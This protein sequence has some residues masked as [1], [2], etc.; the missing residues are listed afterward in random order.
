[1]KPQEGLPMEPILIPVSYG[2]LLDKV[3][4]LR[5]KLNRIKDQDKLANVSKE[6]RLLEEV[7]TKSGI[8]LSDLPIQELE[9]INTALWD[10]EDAIRDKERKREF[11]EEF[12]QLA[13]SVYKINDRR[14]EVKLKINK[15]YS[16][17]LV[18]EKS[19]QPY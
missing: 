18:E 14:F 11:D 19:Y 17:S 16:S 6:L 3:T 13:R 7:C 1:M 9:E 2:E 12:V 5:I 8:N 10:I 4:I 15:R